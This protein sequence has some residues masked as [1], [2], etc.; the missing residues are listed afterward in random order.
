MSD[1]S[2]ALIAAAIT[3]PPTLFLVWLS[4]RNLIARL[5]DV[6]EAWNNHPEGEG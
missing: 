4:V 3:V 5:R 2:A 6:S 1:R